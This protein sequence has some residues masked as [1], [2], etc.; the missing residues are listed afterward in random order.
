MRVHP[1]FLPAVA[2]ALLAASLHADAATN[3]AFVASFGN[4]VNAATNCTI[5]MPCR[6][7]ATA[8]TITNS[9]GEIVALD[10]AGYGPVTIDRSVS[11]YG[12]D[13]VY[14]GIT[15]A[16]GNGVTISTAGVDVVLKG[17]TINGVGGA[18]GILMTNGA[19]LRVENCTVTGFKSA[20]NVAAINVRALATVV[21]SN[22]TVANSYVGIVLDGGAHANLSH[23][24]ASGATFAG[25]ALAGASNA[26]TTAVVSDTMA[27][28]NVLGYGIAVVGQNISVGSFGGCTSCVRKISVV[29][30]VASGNSSGMAALGAGATM[31]VSTSSA[32]NNSAFG[33]DQSNSAILRSA[34]NN[35][36]ADNGVLPVNGVVTTGSLIY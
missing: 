29:N 30:S 21:V 28:D 22:T 24:K 15:V 1:L 10:S 7:F 4:D 27:F 32:A 3:R 14:A 8:L 36:L 26:T 9:G 23:V 5:G 31:N 12:P 2:I 20:Q 13:G 19:S 35:M 11:I 17:L 18:N 34:Q 33:F 6:G 25:I 16:S